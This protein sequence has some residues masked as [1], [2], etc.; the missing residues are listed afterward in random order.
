[1]A[2]STGGAD[3]PVAIWREFCAGLLAAGDAS[4]AVADAQDPLELTDGLAQLSLLLETALRWYLR[5]SDPDFPRFIEINDTPEVADNLFAAVRGDA[6]YRLTGDI[7]SLFDLNISVHTAWGWLAPSKV[8]GDLGRDDLQVDADGRFELILSA[9]EHAGNWLPLPA[10]AH[11][12]QI[13]EYHA[14]WG[15][16]RPGA[17]NIERVGAEGEAPSARMEPGELAGK[18]RSAVAWAQNYATFHQQ[19]QTRI[20]PAEQNSMRPPAPQT[21]GNSH[22]WYGFGRFSLQPDEALV[23]EFEEPEARLWS[24]QWLLSPWYENPDILNRITGIPGREAHVDADGRV[25]IVFAER[26]PGV[27]NWLDVSGYPQGLFVTRWI[28][29]EQGP[30]TRL[31]VVPSA[32]LRSHLPPATP[33]IT[34]Q[35]RAA[36]RARRRAH[37]VHRRR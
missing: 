34:P 15:Q 16:H 3:A 11:F 12:V 20:F 35:Q 25:R 27:P 37:L 32:D 2:T 21:G 14:D 26:D 24:V 8:S 23:L 33:T 18:L 17:F 10:D 5:G 36:Q 1:M 28:W 7:S 22:I 13:R 4:L 6:T 30:P 29:C 19:V 9:K 31:S